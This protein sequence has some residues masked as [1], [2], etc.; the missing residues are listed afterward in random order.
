MKKTTTPAP[1]PAPASTNGD[2]AALATAL[3]T[4]RKAA[5]AAKSAFF[6]WATTQPTSADSEIVATLVAAGLPAKK[7]ANMLRSH[8]SLQG[9]P[10][11]E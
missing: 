2:A 3:V 5:I 9:A 6:A 11:D 7:A 10:A 1:T 8:R 4:S